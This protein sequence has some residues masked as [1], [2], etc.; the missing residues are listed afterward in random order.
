M[1][2]HVDNLVYLLES[3]ILILV[4]SFVISGM[5]AI[6]C[7]FIANNLIGN[8]VAQAFKDFSF[9]DAALIASHAA[10]SLLTLFF[11]SSSQLEDLP[12]AWHVIIIGVLVGITKILIFMVVIRVVKKKNS[13][14]TVDEVVLIFFIYFF[15]NLILSTTAVIPI[16]AAINFLINQYLQVVFLCTSYVIFTM[17]FL[18]VLDK[19]DMNK[20]FVFISHRLA[21]KIAIFATSIITLLAISLVFIFSRAA[22]SPAIVQEIVPLGIILFLLLIGFVRTLKSAHQYEVVVPERYHNMKRILTLLNLKAESAETIDELKEMITATID[23]MDIK[24]A[25][26]E[27]QKSEDEPEDFDAFIKNAIDSLKLNHKSNVEINT[28]IQ[29]FESHKNVSAMNI[30]Y[31][32]GT[33]LENAIENANETGTE[34]P[35]LV[36]ILSTEHVLFIKVANE[37]ESKDP[38]ELYNMLSKGYS[39]K[40]K[41]GRGFGLSKLKKLVESQQGNMIVTQE[42]N[43]IL[44]ANYIAFTLNF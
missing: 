28:T 6:H 31:M 18:W 29:Y 10:V 15:F 1:V 21:L 9:K 5:E 7:Y 22:L 11:M 32:L 41:V 4:S 40:E 19:V 30:T 23:L 16:L 43:P 42:I 36:D 33:L 20:F 12:V 37:A 13:S 27:P 34:Y 39:T 14:T 8:K 26:T 38:Q 25:K 3:A 24:V 2:I 17:L 35:I 44:Q